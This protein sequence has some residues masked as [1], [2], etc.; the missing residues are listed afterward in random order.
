[1]QQ[2]NPIFWSFPIGNWLSTQV[3][4]SVFFPLT[5]LILCFNLD[6]WK[7]GLVVSAI[8]FFS[9]LCHELFGHV[10]MARMTNGSGEEVLIWPLGGLAFVQPDRTFRSQFLTPAGGPLV[11]LLLCGLTFP[12]ILYSHHPEAFATALNPFVLP[13]VDLSRSKLLIGNLLLLCFSL[14][15]MLFLINLIPV[16]PLDGG[17]MLQACL[18]TRL[19]V[20]VSTQ[21][22]IRVGFFMAIIMLAAGLI[23]KGMW[24]V[25]IGSIVLILNMRE[26]MQLQMGESYDESFMGYDFSQG[27]TSLEQSSDT[28]RDSRK[29]FWQRRREKRRT[30][31][32]EREQLRDQEVESQLDL[33]LDKVHSQGMDALTQAERRQLNRVS[34]RFRKKN[35]D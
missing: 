32:A 8:L 10:V 19:P 23:F 24:T 27:Y 35:R 25:T 1:M 17:R 4:V 20:P 3:N 2:R 30:E 15:W 26:W 18:S 6:D 31:Q 22:Y 33:L 34:D 29:T 21:I 14:N 7:L 12:A 5:V 11:N 28:H 16:H 9:V 13:P